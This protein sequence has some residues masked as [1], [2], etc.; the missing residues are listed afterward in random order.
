MPDED[1]APIFLCDRS[2]GHWL[3]CYCLSC[4]PAAQA[5]DFDTILIQ[6]APAELSAAANVAVNSRKKPPTRS[7]PTRMQNK[8]QPR[9][10]ARLDAPI[11][12]PTLYPNPLA[13]NMTWTAISNKTF[14]E[15]RALANRKKAK[16]RRQQVAVQPQPAAAAAAQNGIEQQMRKLLEPMLTAELSFA[17]RATDLN[18]G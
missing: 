18:R 17:A 13:F 16:A 4:C 1:I 8:R 2:R 5:E 12:Y 7:R 11:W 9:N 14:A 3:P 15:A 10:A 6:A